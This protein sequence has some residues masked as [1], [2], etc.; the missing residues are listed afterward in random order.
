MGTPSYKNRVG[1]T[2]TGTPGTGTITLNAAE[3]GYQTFASA[4]G[5]NANVDILIEEGSAWEIARDCTYTHSGT[6]VSRGTLEASSTGSALSLTS[7]AK[8]YVIQTAER[9]NNQML[10]GFSAYGDGSSTQTI[11]ATTTT[12][13]ANIYTELWDTGGFFTPSTGIFMPT[14]P[15]LWMIGGTGVIDDMGADKYLALYINHSTD[16]SSWSTAGSKGGLLWRGCQSATSM[17]MGGSGAIL[18]EANGTTDRFALAVF[19][20]SATS[21]VFPAIAA[22]RSWVRFWARYLGGAT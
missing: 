8:V 15:G 17:T 20:N 13:V 14:L 2:V 1:M 18:V 21:E 7:A 19:H 22:N 12:I 3:T 10:S 5:A 16:G 6:T 4:Y 9:L 11:N